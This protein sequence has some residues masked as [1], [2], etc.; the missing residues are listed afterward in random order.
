MKM[1]RLPVVIYQLVRTTTWVILFGSFFFLLSI[2]VYSYILLQFLTFILHP[3]LLFLFPLL[4]EAGTQQQRSG[5]QYTTTK[6]WRPGH[7]KKVEAG[8]S[9]WKSG[10]WDTS[11]KKWKPEHAN[12]VVA[13]LLAQ[14]IVHYHQVRTMTCFWSFFLFPSFPLLLSSSLPVIVASCCFILGTQTSVL[15]FHLFSSSS[16][17]SYNFYDC[18]LV[19]K[20]TI[21]GFLTSLRWGK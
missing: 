10:G 19:I 8:T 1:W 16:W 6:K 18:R 11:R 4:V 5:G 12:E 20:L 21:V 15:L 2:F 13:V 17:L 7:I 3:S 9:P 14:T